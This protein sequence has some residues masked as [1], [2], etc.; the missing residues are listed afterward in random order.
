M[1]IVKYCDVCGK[2]CPETNDLCRRG[3]DSYSI[4]DSIERDTHYFL[5]YIN[6]N[7]FCPECKSKLL[8]INPKTFREVLCFYTKNI[9]NA[10]TEDQTNEDH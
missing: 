2:K 4:A 8:K 7:D 10:Q 1:S 9:I 6:M 5:E 3:S